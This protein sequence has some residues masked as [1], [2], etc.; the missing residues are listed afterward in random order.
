VT[1]YIVALRK[2]PGNKTS[3]NKQRDKNSSKP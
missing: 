3:K 1:G 2:M